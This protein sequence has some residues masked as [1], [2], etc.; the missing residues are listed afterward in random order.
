MKKRCT[1]AFIFI[2]LLMITIF[3]PV[4]ASSKNKYSILIDVEFNKLHLFQG[5]EC[6]KTYDICS[7]K[8]STPSPLGTFTIIHKDTWGEGFGGRWM[9]FN[10]PWGKYGIHGTLEPGTIGSA[11]SHGCIRMKNKEVKELYNIVSYGTKVTI[12]GNGYGPF[13]YGLKTLKS[14]ATG[15]DVQEIQKRLSLLGYFNGSVNGKFDSNLESAIK[16]FQKAKK[17]PVR[18]RIGSLEYKALGITLMD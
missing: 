10:V 2:S 14:G 5:N 8:Y 11:A 4:I 18:A 7:G 12:M 3:I 13:H 17:L 15:S 9:G 6:I 1:I 16:K